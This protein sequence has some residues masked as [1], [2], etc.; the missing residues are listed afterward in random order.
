MV[1]DYQNGATY[2]D[3]REWAVVVLVKMEWRCERII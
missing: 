2:V 3:W 1:V